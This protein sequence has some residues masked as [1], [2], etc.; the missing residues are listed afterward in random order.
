MSTILI[1]LFLQ[2][3]CGFNHRHRTDG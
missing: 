3:D 2:R 1:N